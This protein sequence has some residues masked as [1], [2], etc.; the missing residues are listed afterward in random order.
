MPLTK[1]RETE[2]R[3]HFRVW[4][5]LAPLDREE[6]EFFARL[7]IEAVHWE[8]GGADGY[9]AFRQK[10]AAYDQAAVRLEH[11]KGIVE[12]E[13]NVVAL[14]AKRLPPA[15]IGIAASLITGGAIVLPDVLDEWLQQIVALIPISFSA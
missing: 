12:A 2:L 15:A 5:Y 1:E 4:A 13:T 7:W 3:Q 9:N 6:A 8:H 10:I 14:A 11:D